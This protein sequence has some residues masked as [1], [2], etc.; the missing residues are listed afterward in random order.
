[1]ALLVVCIKRFAERAWN[2]RFNK[3]VSNALNYLH[4]HVTPSAKLWENAKILGREHS[5]VDFAPY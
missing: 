3:G 1:M 5:I 4:Q 2:D